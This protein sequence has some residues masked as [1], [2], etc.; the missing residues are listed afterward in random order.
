[1]KTLKKTRRIKAYQ[2]PIEITEEG[3]YFIARC[4]LWSDCYAQGKSIDEATTEIIAVASSLIELYQEEKLRIPLVQKKSST[5]T[6][7][8]ISFDVPI[9]S[10]V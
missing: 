3:D 7:T 6:S 2:L 9:F 8:K 10:S 5:T 1:M 4:P